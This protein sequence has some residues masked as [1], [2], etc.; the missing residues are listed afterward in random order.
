LIRATPTSSKCCQNQTSINSITTWARR[1]CWVDALACDL[2]DPL[3]PRRHS[4]P[5]RFQHGVK[6]N[7]KYLTMERASPEQHGA[8]PGAPGDRKR[9]GTTD[10]FV[11][12]RK[13]FGD[14]MILVPLLQDRA[15]KNRKYSCEQTS[16][17]D[18]YGQILHKREPK[19][20]DQD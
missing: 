9:N 19:S 12:L 14:E 6:P 7:L 17:N 2:A 5:F 10:Q 8:M 1:L 3:P 13:E 16:S 11:E 20:C 18:A 4:L 15:I